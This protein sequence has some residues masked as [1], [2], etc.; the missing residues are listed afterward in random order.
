MN[1][2]RRVSEGL[3]DSRR[4]FE[5]RVFILLTISAIITGFIA[6]IGD[7]ITGEHII[8]IIVLAGTVVCV[9]VITFFSVKKGRID[10]GTRLIALGLVFIIIPGV[11]YFGGGVEGG[12]V[13]WVVFSY[14]YIGILLTGAWR[15]AMLILL[16]VMAVLDT[17]VATIIPS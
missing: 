14:L 8:E 2:F 16:T 12:G 3:R 5:E 7:I 13:V 11:F 1:L 9:P 15:R 17:L 4:S 6:F 10:I